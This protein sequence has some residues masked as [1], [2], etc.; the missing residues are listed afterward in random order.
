[1]EIVIG[2]IILLTAGI[3]IS[4]LARFVGKEI[5]KFSDIYKF[6]IKLFKKQRV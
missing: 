3:I 5:F 2:I 1:M 4:K 6:F